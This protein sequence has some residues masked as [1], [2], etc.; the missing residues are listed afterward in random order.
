VVS[1]LGAGIKKAEEALTVN[2]EQVLNLYEKG[3]KDQD[4]IHVSRLFRL[5]AGYLTDLFGILATLLWTGLL[6]SFTQ[7]KY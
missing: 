1:F 7:L 5:P 6:I 3:L 4:L 2:N